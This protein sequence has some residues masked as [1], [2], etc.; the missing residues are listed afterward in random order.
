MWIAMS[1]SFV[2]VTSVSDD[3]TILQVRARR[4]SHLRNLLGE[5]VDVM[6]TEDRDYRYRSFVDRAAFAT[7]IASRIED[8]RYGNFKAWTKVR[9]KELAGLYSDMWHLHHEYQVSGV[10]GYYYVP[11]WK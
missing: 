8:I 4:E 7:L 3:S 2:S 1:D 6:T 5:H 10:S 11:K 9:D